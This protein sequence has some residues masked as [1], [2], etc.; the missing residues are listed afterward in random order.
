MN[1]MILQEQMPAT[2]WCMHSFIA[3][4]VLLMRVTKSRTSAKPF[5]AHMHSIE[6]HLLE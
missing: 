4:P 6:I 3:W 2:K 5:H 1:T